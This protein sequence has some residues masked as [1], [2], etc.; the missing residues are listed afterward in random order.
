M[1]AVEA[2]PDRKYDV[3]TF[4]DL[5]VDLMVSG[6]DVTPR[7]GQT[8]KLVDDYVIEM[9]GSCSLF[10]CQA[11]KLG[12]RVGILGRVGDDAFGHLILNRLNDAGVDTSE[13]VVDPMLKTGLGI[14]LCH[15]GDRAILTYVGSINALRPRDVTDTYLASTRHL[16]YGS[17]FLQKG[18]AAQAPE[19][20]QRA[21]SLEVSISLDTNWDPHERWNSGLH[22]MLP[23][24]DVLMPNESE[25]RFISGKEDRDSAVKAL[26]DWG[27]PIVALKLGASGANVYTENDTYVCTVASAEGGDSV[28]AG[29]S[30]DAGFLAGWLR[31]LPV[32][33]CLEI[34]C[35]C[36]R[37]VA[38]AV[39]GLAGQPTWEQICRI[40]DIS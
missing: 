21:R 12:L 29:D 17:F 31:G 37:S 1:Y 38:N 35:E 5:C 8:E 28:G 11:S 40:L 2:R 9:G 4:G 34:A 22:K 33:L 32:G 16:H 30:F 19:I 24:I 7:F 14:A 36:G 3:I 27:V 25:A 23:L 26:Q 39:G 6:D 20:A 15:G 18:L 10:A 13:V